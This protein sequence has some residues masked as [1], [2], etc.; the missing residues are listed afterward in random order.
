[1]LAIN[2]QG[3]HMKKKY[4]RKEMHLNMKIMMTLG[5]WTM[6]MIVIMLEIEM[7]FDCYDTFKKVISKRTIKHIYD[8]Y[9]IHNEVGRVITIYKE[10]Y[11]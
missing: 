2:L 6:V 7:K 10:K 1:M 5:V 11:G 4:V 3:N 9:F 8:I